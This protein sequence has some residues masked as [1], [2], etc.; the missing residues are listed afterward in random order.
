MHIKDQYVISI[1]YGIISEGAETVNKTEDY[2]LIKYKNEPC[3]EV[4][5]IFKEEPGEGI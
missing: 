5:F 4:D 1:V 3:N 2:S